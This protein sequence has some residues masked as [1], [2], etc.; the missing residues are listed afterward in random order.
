MCFIPSVT[1]QLEGNLLLF[2]YINFI[3]Q[4]EV[5]IR[6]LHFLLSSLGYKIQYI[7]TFF[8]LDADTSKILMFLPFNIP[9]FLLLMY[10]TS[11]IPSRIWVRMFIGFL[12]SNVIMCLLYFICIAHRFTLYRRGQNKKKKMNGWIFQIYKTEQHRSISFFGMP[13]CLYFYQL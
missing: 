10:Y 4:L 5:S 7:C 1:N 2:S 8:A 13:R 12:T 3:I 6:M 9:G 11:K